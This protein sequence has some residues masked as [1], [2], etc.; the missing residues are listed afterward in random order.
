MGHGRTTRAGTSDDEGGE[1]SI[2]DLN[3]IEVSLRTML[4]DQNQRLINTCNN[5]N[6][7]IEQNAKS[8]AELNQLLLGLSMQ[9][10]KLVESNENRDSANSHNNGEREHINSESHNRYPNFAARMTKVDFPKFDGTELRSWLYRCNQFFQ[11]DEVTDSQKVRLAAIHLEA[12]ALLWHQTYMQR[13]NQVLPSWTQYTEDITTRFGD[14]YDDPMADL[15]ALKQTGSV[16]DY[17]DAF[18]AL[19][20]RLTLSEEYLLSCYLGGLADEIQLA[21][22]MFTPKS[23]QQAL[24]LAKLQEAAS[25]AQKNK[26][27]PILPTPPSLQ[28]LPQT[29]SKPYFPTTF[30]TTKPPTTTFKQLT[31]KPNTTR[32]TLTPAE[33]SEKRAKNL[34]FWCDERYVPGHKCKGKKPQFFH[35]EM[36]EEI[37]D[38]ELDEVAPDTPAETEH[39]WLKFR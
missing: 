5:N 18:D 30:N 4:E 31:E 12:K 19:T 27:K 24:C 3:R 28:K 22:R 39:Q 23:I 38:P 14:L 25:I 7:N 1:H 32:K 17:H 20:S 36:E 16:Q 33:L 15:K 29:S 13:R 10:A 6:V 35:L 26:S 11:L 37:E 21:V 8:I 34:C 2:P 9:V